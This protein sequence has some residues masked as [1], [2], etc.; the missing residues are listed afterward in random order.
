[1]ADE[2]GIKV[3]Q[4]GYD[5]K[6]CTPDQLVF[7][8]KYRTLRVRSQGSGAIT[9]SGGRSVTIAH[10][11][12]YVPY[13]LVHSTP[14]PALG[15]GFFVAGDYFISPIVPVITGAL[16][17]LRDVRAYADD[18][19][20]YIELGDDFG[21]SF[22]HTNLETNDYAWQYSG[23]G[24][25]YTAGGAYVGNDPPTF[26]VEDG[27]IRIHNV[28]IAT[29]QTILE[30][31]LF[32]YAVASAGTPIKYK[33]Y[34]IDEDNT[35]DFGGNPFGRSK[36]SASMTAGA[37]NP[38]IPGY[39]T[40]TV[41]NIVQE[42][43]NRGGWEQGN[44]MGFLLFDDNSDDNKDFGFTR[45][46]DTHPYGSNSYLRVLLNNTLCNYKYTIFYNKIE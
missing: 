4:P 31:R 3:S 11:L 24:G 40:P 45:T 33:C 9:H 10:N 14:D 22:Y 2:Y 29:N 42:I 7:S 34:G 13:F 23:S 43:V 12:G 46:G 28:N 37:A 19:N 27:G 21:F 32:L 6:N 15:V 8:S 26:D 36:T 5:V 20:L 41:T 30:A 1:M 17:L 44:H 35:G 39:E 25:G 16:H 38:S 18:T